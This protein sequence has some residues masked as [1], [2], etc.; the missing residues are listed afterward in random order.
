MNVLGEV[1]GSNSCSFHGININHSA[2]ARNKSESMFV[3]RLQTYV[4][5]YALS[6]AGEYDEDPLRVWS[7]FEGAFGDV[8]VYRNSCS[9]FAGNYLSTC[10]PCF[11][12]VQ[13]KTS[14][15]IRLGGCCW[16]Y[17]FDT[18]DWMHS[19]LYTIWP[20]E[21]GVKS[22]IIII[23]E[24]VNVNLI[25]NA[26]LPNDEFF[27]SGPQMQALANGQTIN[28]SGVILR[29]RTWAET[30]IKLG[31]IYDSENLALPAEQFEK[32]DWVAI[33]V[34]T[35]DCHHLQDWFTVNR[36]VAPNLRKAV[37]NIVVEHPF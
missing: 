30:L 16:Y 32:R 4:E 28:V 8:I 5:W 26:A 23:V 11:L 25:K 20:N 10:D 22:E 24:G 21:S 1:P 3:R 33:V 18:S 19:C 13:V 7:A 17:T 29:N 6:P 9:H 31:E 27:L 36:P 2:P 37:R 34:D 35:T 14:H 15:A 12:G